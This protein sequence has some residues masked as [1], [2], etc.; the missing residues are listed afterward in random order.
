MS[1][2]EKI[3]NSPFKLDSFMIIES[4]IERE[5]GALQEVKVKISPKGILN[6]TKKNFSLFLDV[7]VQDNV[8][9]TINISCVGSFRFKNDIN[10]QQLSNY[11]LINA[12]SIIFPYI[13]S[14]ISALTALSGLPAVNLPVMNLTSLKE[15]LKNNIK[16]I[17][18]KSKS[19][20]KAKTG[21]KLIN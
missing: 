4:H 14:Y 8:S 19:T 16:D 17:S 12:P 10:E 20:T 15:D 3:E 6:R 11:F 13:R 9:V 21:N 2:L 18:S 1:V 5:P 7:S